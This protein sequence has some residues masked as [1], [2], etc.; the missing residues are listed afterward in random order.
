MTAHVARGWIVAAGVVAGAVA[1]AAF[2][3]G[4]LQAPRAAQAGP[5]PAAL[6]SCPAP[7]D[8][9]AI[10][11]ATDAFAKIDGIPGDSANAAHVGEV[12][13]TAVRGGLLAGGTGLCGGGA[14]GRVVFDPIV[15]EK[16]VDRASVGLAAAALTG[17]HIKSVRIALQS[18]GAR[19]L[20][21]F[22]YD[23]TDARVVSIRQVRQGNTLEEE[24]G[25]DFARIAYSFVPVNANG[26]PGPTIPFCWDI[27]ANHPC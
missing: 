5:V 24:V 25:F 27:A 14:A 10:S 19:P 6:A 20:V 16:R 26:T 3:V 23:L 21:F 8:P 13:L 18:T 4:G 17:R 15:V 12:D 11:R 1:G 9:V 22:T 2:I 7:V